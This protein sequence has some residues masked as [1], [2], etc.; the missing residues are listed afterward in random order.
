MTYYSMTL[1]NELNWCHTYSSFYPDSQRD[2]TW[3]WDG[4]LLWWVAENIIILVIS[5]LWIFTWYGL[6]LDYQIAGGHIR[7]HIFSFYLRKSLSPILKL[8]PYCN[9]WFYLA[10]MWKLLKSLF[11]M[12]ELILCTGLKWGV[13]P[14]GIYGG[15][16]GLLFY[17]VTRGG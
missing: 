11:A 6:T 9:K 4:L 3:K 13:P 17:V 16:R 8:A 1:G 10:Y 5:L 7:Y 2:L 14:G 15:Q 12:T